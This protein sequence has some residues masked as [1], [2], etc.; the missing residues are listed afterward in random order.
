MSVKSF[1]QYITE[2][3][4]E[5]TISWGRFNPPTI[6]HEKLMDAVAKVAKGG[7][8]R[9][10]AS[11]STDAKKNPLDYTSKVKFMRKMFPRHARAIILDPSIKTLF[12]LLNKLYNEG[13]R[14]VN[15][16][17]GSD[18]VPEY[19]ALT[20][21]YNGVKGRHGFYNFEGGVNIISAG[22]RDPDADGAEGMSASK[23]RAAA[24]DNDYQLF[25]KGMP[26]GFKESKALF[27]AVR[28]SMGLKESYDF[29]SHIQL[30]SV[31]DTR[32][33][34]IAGA[35]YQ[36]GNS[37]IVKETDEVGTVVM[38]GS[39][40]VLVEMACG[41]K[42]RKWLESVKK[43]ATDVDDNVVIVDKKKKTNCKESF[44]SFSKFI[45]RK[46]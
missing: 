40:Y 46:S 6:G 23:L 41:K 33:A 18:R 45:N 20:N 24:T 36:V 32:E 38:L 39:N 21:K 28:K 29:R 10:Y 1:S 13:Y 27:N 5:V 8:Y 30:D 25:T 2:A 15:F 17:A 34:Y 43:V 7:E 3:T 35:L 31:S 14:K 12:D 44:T 9:I 16:I 37:V 42:T 11:Q 19:E 22:E 4:K 26:R